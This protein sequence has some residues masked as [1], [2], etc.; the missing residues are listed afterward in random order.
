MT[1]HLK[2]F[3]FLIIS[4]WVVGASSDSDKSEAFHAKALDIFLFRGVT[5]T[6][7]VSFSAVP[8][9]CCKMMPLETKNASVIRTAN[10]SMNLWVRVSHWNSVTFVLSTIRAS[11][12]KISSSVL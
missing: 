2:A 12:P 5:G 9:L 11:N 10:E 3:F 7:P 8:G 1:D 6:K 4:G